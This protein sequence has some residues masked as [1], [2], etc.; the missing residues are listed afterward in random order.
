MLLDVTYHSRTLP[1]CSNLQNVEYMMTKKYVV[2]CLSDSKEVKTNQCCQFYLII[3]V[4]IN[5]CLT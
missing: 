3:K 2:V 4:R 5:T 1:H